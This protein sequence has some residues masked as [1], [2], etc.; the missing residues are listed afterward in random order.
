M[1]HKN[2]I[3]KKKVH[4]FSKEIFSMLNMSIASG[5]K[6]FLLTKRFWVLRL[7]KTGD[8][9]KSS[10]YWICHLNCLFLMFS[11]ELFS[12]NFKIF[13]AWFQSFFKIDGRPTAKEYFFKDSAPLSQIVSE[14]RNSFLVRFDRS[15]LILSWCLKFFKACRSSGNLFSPHNVFLW[16]N[17]SFS[18]N[19]ASKVF[20]SL[21]RNFSTKCFLK[22]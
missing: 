19:L 10:F 21:A 16:R 2:T 22:R 18:K 3:Y 17:D 7:D 1:W 5:W 14:A 15:H 8:Q 13:V 11:A 6:S 12:E 9:R 4:S 20:F